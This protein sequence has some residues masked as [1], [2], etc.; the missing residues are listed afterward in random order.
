MTGRRA[1]RSLTS[2]SL[3]A[4]VALPTSAAAQHIARIV[5]FGDSDADQGNAFEL[6]YAN[7]QALTICHTGRSSGGSNC[8]DTLSTILNAPVDTFAI[9]GAFAGSNNG[10]LCF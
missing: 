4:L 8:I 7:P 5:A 10:T 2:V 3:A 1:F 6:G 9:G